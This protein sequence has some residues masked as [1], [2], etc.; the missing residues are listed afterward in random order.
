M[1][2]SDSRFFKIYVC[3]SLTLIMLLLASLVAAIA[4]S[5]VKV[6][7][8]AGTV[9][10]KINTFNQNVDKINS[11]LQNINSQL[12]NENIKIQAL[13]TNGL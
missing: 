2:K 8:E 3:V 12:Q 11:N 9:D 1:E 5:G 6:K 13:P 4:Y 10:N 7:N